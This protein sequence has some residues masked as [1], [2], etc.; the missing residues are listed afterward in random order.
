MGKNQYE[1]DPMISVFRLPF[2]DIL[3]STEIVNSPEHQ[4]LY[5]VSH[6]QSEVYE[7][8]VV[9]FRASYSPQRRMLGCKLSAHIQSNAH[10]S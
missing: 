4:L 5:C 3:A 10:P 2:T 7:V 8:A 6:N 9:Y 1:L